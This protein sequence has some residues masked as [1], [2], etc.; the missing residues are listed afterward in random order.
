MSSS[1]PK[2]DEKKVILPKPD[3]YYYRLMNNKEKGLPR[4]YRWFKRLNKFFVISLYRL[5]V[6]P[7]FGAGWAWSMLM[8][9]TIGRKTGK[10]RRNP[11]EFHPVNS[12]IHIA[13]PEERKLTG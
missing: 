3:T 10:T 7:L 5:R 13:G 2:Q 4:S 8:I 6:L 9:T 11:L 1:Q 12:V